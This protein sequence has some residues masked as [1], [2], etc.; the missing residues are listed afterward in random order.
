MSCKFYTILS[1]SVK[2][3][4][5]KEELVFD[6]DPASIGRWVE[7]MAECGREGEEGDIVRRY[8]PVIMANFHLIG[9]F[10]SP[11]DPIRG[12]VVNINIRGNRSVA[13]SC[14]T[15]SW[16][17]ILL[18]LL[19]SPPVL[20]LSRIYLCHLLLLLLLLLFLLLSNCS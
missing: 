11:Y 10:S 14:F 4:V 9:Y 13:C 15:S 18:H 3:P 16:L 19:V 8:E 12:Y 1:K 17:T 20:L 2:M 7:E 6:H 5:L